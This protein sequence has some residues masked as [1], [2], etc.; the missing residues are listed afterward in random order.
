MAG[1]TARCAKCGARSRLAVCAACGEL[2][3]PACS[4]DSLAGL[5]LCKPSCSYGAR[6]EEALTIG[7]LFIGSCVRLRLDPEE[8]FEKLLEK[9]KQTTLED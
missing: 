5:P 2:R 1:V 8:T 4:R 6:L 3:C 9:S 7:R